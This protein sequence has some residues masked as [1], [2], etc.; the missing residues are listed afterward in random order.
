M[1]GIKGRAFGPRPPVT[2]EELVPPDYVYRHLEDTLDLRF[3]RDLVR[4]AYAPS[5]RP[6]I[7]PVVF[8]KLHLVLFF[9]GL[10]SE[11]QLMQVVADRFSLRSLPRLRPDGVPA[12][13]LQPDAHSGALRISGLPSVLRE[14]RGAVHRCQVGLGPG[15]LH[16]RDEG[17]RQ[18]RAR[19]A[20][21]PLR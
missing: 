1:M 2:L 15:T 8:F 14:D 7:D 19:F 20:S 16:R 12:R 9:E 21:A 10:R 5:G 6:S 11:R 3:V 4:D 18:R 13:S 17:R